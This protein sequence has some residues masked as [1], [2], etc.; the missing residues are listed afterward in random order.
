VNRFVAFNE[1]PLLQGA[2]KVSRERM[3][4]VAFERYATFDAQRRKADAAK[5]DDED[6]RALEQIER[7]ASKRRPR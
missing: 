5:A 7:D 4:Q 6:I 1:R 3:E 2:G